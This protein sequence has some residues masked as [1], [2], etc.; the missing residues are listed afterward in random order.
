MLTLAFRKLDVSIGYA[1]WSGA[2]G[3]LWFREPVMPPRVLFIGFILVG[4]IGLHLVSAEGQGRS[5]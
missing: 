4:L 2:A 5:D 3:V 1:V